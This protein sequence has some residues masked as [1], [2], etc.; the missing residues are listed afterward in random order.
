MVEI[1]FLIPFITG[2][3]AFFLPRAAGRQLLVATGAVHLLLSLLL[4]KN[5]PTAIFESYFAVTPEGLLSLLVISL[6]FFLIS[7]FNACHQMK[8]LSCDT[9]QQLIRSKAAFYCHINALPS[10]LTCAALY[11]T[12][13]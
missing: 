8:P 13:H 7:T 4:W 3:I 1:V 10:T 11:A 5:K 2:I 12:Y 9:L 6:L